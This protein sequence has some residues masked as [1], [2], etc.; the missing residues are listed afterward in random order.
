MLV[1]FSDTHNHGHKK[2]RPEGPFLYQESVRSILTEV[3]LAVYIVEIKLA[4]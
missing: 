4:E 1:F 3:P 2:K